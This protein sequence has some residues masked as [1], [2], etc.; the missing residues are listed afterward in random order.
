MTLVLHACEKE[1]MV[2]TGQLLAPGAHEQDTWRKGK[3]RPSCLGQGSCLAQSRD[4]RE[5]GWPTQEGGETWS[6]GGHVRDMT[7]DAQVEVT[8]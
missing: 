3:A 2:Q 1:Y 7:P 8:M 6:L 4:P 5:M